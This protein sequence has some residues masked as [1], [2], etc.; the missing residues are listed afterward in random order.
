MSIATYTK[1]PPT[2]QTKVDT[3]IFKVVHYLLANDLI[4]YENEFYI[5]LGLGKQH[6][7]DIK[8]GSRSF[9]VA[10]IQAIIKKFK[11]NAYFILGFEKKMF[12]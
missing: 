12:R 1:T 11:V 10:H 8:I 2:P 9:T 6:Y 4:T 5:P 7:R 3:N